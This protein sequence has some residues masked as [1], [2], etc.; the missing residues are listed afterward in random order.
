VEASVEDVGEVAFEGS[1]GFSGGFAFSDFASEIGL[2]LGVVALLDD[3][4]AVER[5]VELAVAAA[6]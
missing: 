2:G 6:V 4:D 1:A 5:G 3:R